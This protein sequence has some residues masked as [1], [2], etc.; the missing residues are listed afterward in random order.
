MDKHIDEELNLLEFD[1]RR[2]PPHIRN[3]LL[4]FLAIFTV[5]G[6]F[7]CVDIDHRER[8]YYGLPLYF[9]AGVLFD[10][11]L[12]VLVALF[13]QSVNQ[14]KLR[15]IGKIY[16]MY[17]YCPLMPDILRKLHPAPTDH[18]KVW[19][20]FLL[21]ICGQYDEAEAQ[22]MELPIQLLPLREY[23]M[24]M[25]AKLM[26]AMLTDDWAAADKLFTAEQDMLE[27]TYDSQPYFAD[28]FCPYQDDAI[29]FYLL[30]AVCWELK[31]EPLRAEKMRQK[32][33]AFAMERPQD[34]AE[35]FGAIAELNRLY[36]VGAWDAAEQMRV[37]L[38][39]QAAGLVSPVTPGAR[40][41]LQRLIAQSKHY[42]ELQRK[43]EFFRNP[44][45]DTVPQMPERSTHE[46]QR[47]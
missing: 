44:L 40:Y 12:L 38:D 20:A 10:A 35:M 9:L 13:A 14:Q 32:A 37:R 24:L 15:K 4:V 25:T 45:T 3:F 30:A 19:H 47:S 8:L 29:E 22:F 36:A 27:V 34:E 46:A 28:A 6:F 18:D 39:C 16:P 41:N 2:Q 31:G 21:V 7:K 11:V 43:A 5:G 23:A 42:G 17:G 1:P 33:E 26:L